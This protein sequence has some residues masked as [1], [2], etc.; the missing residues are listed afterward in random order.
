MSSIYNIE[1]EDKQIL[2][3]IGNNLRAERNRK[4]LSQEGL[5][6]KAGLIMGHISK[7]ENGNMNI[8]LTTLIALLKALNIPFD[9]LYDLNDE[10]E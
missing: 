9:K 1:M 2:K 6:E 5:A 4:N 7:I 8:R 10:Q 3:I